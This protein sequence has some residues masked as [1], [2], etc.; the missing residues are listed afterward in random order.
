[1]TAVVANCHACQ[2]AKGNATDI[3]RRRLHANE[4]QL[5]EIIAHDARQVLHRVEDLTP[6]SLT[7]PAANKHGINDRRVF[8]KNMDRAAHFRRTW[9]TRRA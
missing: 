2:V 3:A 6:I 5:S 4:T 1:M 9:E 8:S 7:V